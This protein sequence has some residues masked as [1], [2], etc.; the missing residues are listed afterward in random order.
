MKRKQKKEKKQGVE[1]KSGIKVYRRLLAYVWVYKGL[2][3]VSILGYMVSSATQPLFAELIKT[4]IDTLQAEG[5]PGAMELPFL[6]SGLIIVRSIG[7][8]IGGYFVTRVST[9]VVHDLRC[10]IFSHYT[11]LPTSYF[12][13][14]N[15]GYL[16]SRITH[17]VKQVTGAATGALKTIIK[18]GMT[19]LGLLA[20]LFYINWQLSIVFL[21]IAPVIALIVKIASKRLRMLSKRLQE[22]VGDLTRIASEVVNEHKAVKSYGGET[23]EIKRFS[24]QSRYHRNQTMKLAVT[25]ALQGPAMQIIIALSLSGLMYFALMFM[26]KS[27]T[28]EF[29]GYLTAAFMLPRSIKFISGANGK[30]QKGIAAAESLFSVLDE[31]VEAN[32]GAQILD[33]CKGEIEFRNI[34]FGY[35]GTDRKALNNVS[36]KIRPGET[37]ALVGASGSGKT[38]LVNLLMRFYDYKKGQILIDGCEINKLK[39]ENLREQIAMVNQQVS[40]FD[41]SAKNNIVYGSENINEQRLTRAVENAYAL[42]FIEKLEKGI[43]TQIGEHGVTLSGGQRQRLALA[44]AIYKDAP[45]LILDEATSALDTKSEKYIQAALEKVQKN[46]TSVIIAHRLSTIEKADVIFVMDNGEIIERGSHQKL[47]ALKGVYAE[48]HAMQFKGLGINTA[49]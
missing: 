13:S 34:I 5:R 26:E 17:N 3:A 18:E 8:F 12:D 35:K 40:L 41:E 15:S 31:P 30:I 43:D 27:S 11:R 33:K 23:F 49:N 38:T 2:F 16:I 22:S 7:A 20:Y 25:S 45:I 10:E 4:I 1:K 46:R 14:N 24:K 32:E 28:G 42:E 36:F 47:I 48:L 39:T 19:A 6:F 37:V 21:F 44:R 9:N 29:V